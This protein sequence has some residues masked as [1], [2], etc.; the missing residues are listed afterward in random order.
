MSLAFIVSEIDAFKQTDRHTDMAQ[1]TRLLILIK[2]IYTFGSLPR[3]LL[4]VTYILRNAF[5]AHFQWAKGIKIKFAVSQRTNNI[6]C[7]RIKLVSSEN[8]FS[9]ILPVYEQS[10]SHIENN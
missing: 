8:H 9:C 7:P 3:H 6:M 10:A 1:S 2:N 4:P 5:F